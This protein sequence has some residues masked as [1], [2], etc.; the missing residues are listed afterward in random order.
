MQVLVFELA[1]EKY[2]VET[3]NIQSIDKITSMTK[4]PCAP[5]Y[6][7]G[8]INLRGSIISIFD[9][10]IK[11]GIKNTSRDFESIL[12]IKNDDEQIGMVVDRVV[13]VAEIDPQ[14][15]KNVSLSKDDEKNY[16]LG[17]VNMGDYLVTM[18]NVQDL[19]AVA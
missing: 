17:T 3:Q 12:I 1:N 16:I 18:I 2:A 10:Y 7:K 5:D 14:N 8:L 4:V 6:I 11:L 9:P 19:L 15:I 13:E